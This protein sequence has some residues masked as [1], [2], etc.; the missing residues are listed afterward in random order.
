MKTYIVKNVSLTVDGIVLNARQGTVNFPKE[1][2]GETVA[3][4]YDRHSQPQQ[5]PKTAQ[6]KQEQRRFRK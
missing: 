4:C 1:M 5:K 2:D 6:W 3:I